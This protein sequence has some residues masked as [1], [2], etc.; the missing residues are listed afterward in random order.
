MKRLIIVFLTLGCFVGCQKDIKVSKEIS[1]IKID[2]NIERFDQIFVESKPSDLSDLKQTFP[3]LFSSRYPDSL[4]IEKMA[5][6]LQV[7]LASEVVRSFGDLKDIK[8]EISL[9]FQHLKFYFPE[10][11]TPRVITVT[12]NVDYRNKVI[13]T[14]SIVLIALDNYLG[15]DHEYYQNIP[16]YLVNNFNKNQVT[17]DLA[18]EYGKK[19]AYQ[20]EKRTLL[21]EMIFSGKLLYFKDLVLPLKSDSEKIGYSMEQLNWAVDN[22]R[23]IWG[24]FIENE[25]LFDTNSELLSRFINP[26]PFSKFYLNL[27][28]ETPG[29][30]GQYIGW[31]IVRAYM[32][33][34]D[35]SFADMLIKSAKEIYEKSNFKPRK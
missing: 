15:T 10:F 12:S 7:Q 25:M 18:T 1:K 22:E 13:V 33:N 21:D 3:F 11:K 28:N 26:A 24:Y 27:D 9:L 8:S 35:S 17:P 19:Y 16:Q 34:N 14:D 30:I 29:R 6:S 31:Q 32:K 5:D 20:P 2:L 4:W 23:E